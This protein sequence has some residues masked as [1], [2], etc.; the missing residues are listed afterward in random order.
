[1]QN[2]IGKVINDHATRGVL[3][4]SVTTQSLYDIERNAADEV[5]RQ[6]HQNIQEIHQ[7][8]QQ[9][10]LNKESALNDMKVAFDTLAGNALNGLGNIGQLKEWKFNNI[11][12]ALLGEVQTYLQGTQSEYQLK[13]QTLN[14][15]NQMLLNQ[16]AVYNHIFTNA[17]QSAG[18][19]GQFTEQNWTN[20]ESALNDSKHS[21][22]DFL[23]NYYQGLQIQLQ[24]KQ[25]KFQNLNTALITSLT[26][27]EIFWVSRQIWKIKNLR[28]S[29][30]R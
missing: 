25:N 9:R 15:T 1:M 27:P 2:T 26:T 11:N 21:F 6:Y 28:R 17:I 19:R 20:I 5:A 24:A 30:P 8:S 3:D 16:D 22:D 29:P 4:S 23:S 13:E 18:Q 7:L 10:W 14:N 12:S